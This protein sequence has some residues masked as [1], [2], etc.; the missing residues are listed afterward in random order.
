MYII[1][2]KYQVFKPK[3]YLF[4]LTVFQSVLFTFF[5][6]TCLFPLESSEVKSCLKVLVLGSIWSVEQWKFSRKDVFK[7]L[8]YHLITFMAAHL[9]ALIAEF[10]GC[11]G[12]EEW[13][14]G[15]WHTEGQL[16]VPFACTHTCSSWFLSEAALP[17]PKC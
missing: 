9:L 12:N 3:V 14:P 15:M 16:Y 6:Y 10:Q 2:Q 17:L 13:D 1:I 11:S 7:C 8:Q 5:P 4:N